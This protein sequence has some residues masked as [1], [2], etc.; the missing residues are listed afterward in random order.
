MTKLQCLNTVLL[1]RLHYYCACRK[2][3]FPFPT[4]HAPWAP[5]TLAAGGASTALAILVCS[6]SSPQC[7]VVSSEGVLGGSGPEGGWLRHLVISWLNQKCHRLLIAPS[8]LSG[9]SWRESMWGVAMPCDGGGSTWKSR[10]VHKTKILYQHKGLFILSENLVFE[11]YT[12]LNPFFFPKL[13]H[14]TCTRVMTAIRPTSPRG[15][16]DTASHPSATKIPLASWVILL[17]FSFHQL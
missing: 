7:F 2:M 17:I 5:P 13:L 16:P 9:I 6:E 10:P 15:C 11:S 8:Y 4:P 3:G 14:F 1:P 12:L